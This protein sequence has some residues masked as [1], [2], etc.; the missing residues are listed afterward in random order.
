MKSKKNFLKT[1][2]FP[3]LPVSST[4]QSL[5]LSSLRSVNKTFLTDCVQL[6]LYQS[7]WDAQRDLGLQE[8]L[9]KH[10]NLLRNS[11]QE[12]SRF[13]WCFV[14]VLSTQQPIHAVMRL[15]QLL[16]GH[17]ACVVVP[18]A[19]TQPS[20]SCNTG[21][22]SATPRAKFGFYVWGLTLPFPP[23]PVLSSF[24]SSLPLDRPLKSR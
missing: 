23:S 2:V 21:P 15:L 20:H 8:Q 10:T 11:M 24:L 19:S 9:N 22:E 5:R 17:C 7:S 14:R 4:R 16:A 1:Y 6:G 3:A 12:L 18:A 13:F